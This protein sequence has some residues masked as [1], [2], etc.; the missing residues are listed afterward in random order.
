ML[1]SHFRNSAILALVAVA[2]VAG[3][4]LPGLD[5]SE[6][7]NG[8]RNS[9]H[10]IVF[11]GFAGIVFNHLQKL[12][13]WLAISVTTIAVC[14]VAGSAEILQYAQGA[15]PEVDIVDLLRDISG[16]ALAIVATIMWRRSGSSAISPQQKLISRAISIIIVSL[17]FIPLTAWLTVLIIN[18]MMFPTLL[19]FEEWWETYTYRGINTTVIVDNAATF[20]P[21]QTYRSG[22]NIFPLVSNWE[23]YNYLTF[24]AAVT[25]GKNTKL[26]VRVND[27]STLGWLY[28][29]AMY[30]INITSSSKTFRIPLEKLTIIPEQDPAKLSDV[31]QIVIL[32]P[33]S[34]TH[35]TIMLDEIRLE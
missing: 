5:T 29:D 28:K 31:T 27:S 10:I 8:I 1:A 30:E 35:S 33:R 23:D 4:L 16:A 26:A 25:Q 32:T 12:R 3:H 20:T 14:V 24:T 15:S 17:V 19:A 6:I 2:I 9:L 21:N 13:L 22:L 11:A 18:R 34:K 7:Q